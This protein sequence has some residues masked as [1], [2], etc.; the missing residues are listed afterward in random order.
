MRA[1]PRSLGRQTETLGKSSVLI[2]FVVTMVVNG[3]SA[4]LAKDPCILYKVGGDGRKK[5]Q[6]TENM[7]TPYQ[8]E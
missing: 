8:S 6:K 7:S 3:E 1:I 2:F 5:L 4:Q